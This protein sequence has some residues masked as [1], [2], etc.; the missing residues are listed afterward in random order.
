MPDEQQLAA[1][2]ATRIYSTVKQFCERHPAFTEGGLRF[3]IFNENKNG[4]KESGAIVR[5]GKK[6]LINEPKY[7]ARLEANNQGSSK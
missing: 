4:L 3:E 7:F 5:N 2:Q 6:I 1:I